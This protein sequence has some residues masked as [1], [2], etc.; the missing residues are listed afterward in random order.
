MHILSRTRWTAWLRSAATLSLFSTLVLTSGFY[1][2]PLHEDDRKYSAFTAPMGLF[3]Y[4]R[5]RQ[6]L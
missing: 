5:L 1:N 6:G 2:M 3:E 4:N